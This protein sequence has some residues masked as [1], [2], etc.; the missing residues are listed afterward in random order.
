MGSDGQFERCKEEMKLLHGAAA[1]S[2]STGD[3]GEVATFAPNREDTDRFTPS[4][5]EV[6]HH[7][8]ASVMPGGYVRELLELGQLAFLYRDTLFVHGGLVGGPWKNSSDPR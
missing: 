6:A 7:I 5:D 1:A 2:A 4:D 8:I 3:D